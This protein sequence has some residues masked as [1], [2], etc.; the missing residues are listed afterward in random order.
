MP[1]N[2]DNPVLYVRWCDE[3]QEAFNDLHAR[4][5]DQRTCR[6]LNDMPVGTLW[7]YRHG[8]AG[9]GRTRHYINLRVLERLA[10]AL[11]DPQVENHE[12]ATME[13]WRRRDREHAAA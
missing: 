10:F 5:G 6:L 9:G 1:R 2:P 11:G 4:Y 13:E 7:N 3:I 12:A 8:L